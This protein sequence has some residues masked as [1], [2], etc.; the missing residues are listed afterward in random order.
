MK[1]IYRS[2]TN[3]KICGVCSGIG[4]YLD[5]DANVIRLIFGATAFMGGFSIFVYIL[6][7][8]ILPTEY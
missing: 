5:L 6:A 1:K 3:Q 7:A 2:K 8:V 4:E